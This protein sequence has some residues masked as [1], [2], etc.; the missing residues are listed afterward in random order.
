MKIGQEIRLGIGVNL[1]KLFV[2]FI[3][4]IMLDNEPWWTIRAS[5]N[6]SLYK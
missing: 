1:L 4:D 3:Y 2:Y 6:Y 5:S